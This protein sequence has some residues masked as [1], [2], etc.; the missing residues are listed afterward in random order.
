MTVYMSALRSSDA[1]VP[2]RYGYSILTCV[3]N[4]FEQQQH[5]GDMKIRLW[6]TVFLFFV[7]ACSSNAVEDMS[8]E[9]FGPTTLYRDV[10][11]TN[12]PR[13][14]LSGLSM[15]AQSADL[16]QDG[17]LD[18]VVAHEHRPNIL[19]L[20]DGTGKFSNASTRLPATNRDSEDIGIADFDGDG[21]LDIIIVSEDDMTNE[22]YLN[23]G[24][25]T[26]IDASQR[27]P[28]AGIS[29]AVE[30]FDVNG[31]ALP[32]L[33]IGNNGQNRLVVNIGDATFVDETPERLPLATDITQDVELG[34]VD[35]DGDLDILEGNEGDNRILI[36]DGTGTF[37]NE[38]GARLPLRESQEIT[39]EADFGDLDGDGDLDILFANVT[40][41]VSGGDAQNRILLNDGKGFF[42]DVTS[43][44]FPASQERSFDGD[45]LDIDFDGDNDI[46]TGNLPGNSSSPQLF[47][48]Y[49]NDSTGD[50]EQGTSTIFPSG[51]TG[52]GFDIE[53]ADYN[54]DGV[55][56]LY[57]ASRGSEDFLLFFSAE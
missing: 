17:D 38:T 39:R 3:A 44:N 12:L 54:G 8:E 50:F 5:V 23:D 26:F 13:A 18:I 30:V 1:I 47:N 48:I 40:N 11:E 2:C 55:N 29:N 9:E 34:D 10:S 53:S 6:F 28:V 7:L 21:D 20:N 19:L 46:I 16:D 25:A 32:D 42:V 24:T 43:D 52:F 49:L 14:D 36:N 51:I 35:G 37:T 56:D 57:L 22:L 4:F 27:L 33:L 31:D 15:D 45:I 41:L